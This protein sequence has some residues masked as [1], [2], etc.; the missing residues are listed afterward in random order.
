M[1]QIKNIEKITDSYPEW[2]PSDFAFIKAMDWS[3]GTLVIVFYCQLRAQRYEWPDTSETFFEV[4]I[5]FEKTSGLKLDFSGT[6]L[7]QVSGFEVL[8]VSENGWEKINFRIEDHENESIGFNCEDV[9]INS[10]S[11]PI[12]LVPE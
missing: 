11:K 1:R 8:D 2:C 10:V 5:S 6:G 12:L 3:V 7:H 4:S 9:V